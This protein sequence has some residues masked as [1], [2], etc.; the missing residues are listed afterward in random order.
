MSHGAYASDSDFVD[1][2]RASVDSYLAA[3]DA[4]ETAYRRFYRMPGVPV[5]AHPDL[6][7]ELSAID[8][9]RRKLESLVPHA[10]RLCLRHEVRDS[11]STLLRLNLG[12]YAPQER[13]DSAIGRAERNAVAE[14]LI[15]LKSATQNFAEPSGESGSGRPEAEPRKGSILQRLINFF[16]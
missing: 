11:F 1:A 10:R 9:Q 2:L 13:T 14:S 7:P 4:W 12:V 16:Y 3:V 5:E 8:Q 15:E 6:A